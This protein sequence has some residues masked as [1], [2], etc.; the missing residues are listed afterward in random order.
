MH[1]LHRYPKHRRFARFDFPLL[2]ASSTFIL[3]WDCAPDLVASYAYHE[4]A[5]GDLLTDWVTFTWLWVR[6][7]FWCVGLITG[8]KLRFA[9]V[10]YIMYLHFLF[11]SVLIFSSFFC[12]VKLVFTFCNFLCRGPAWFV[13]GESWLFIIDFLWFSWLRRIFNSAFWTSLNKSGDR[14]CPAPGMLRMDES[15]VDTWRGWYFG[16]WRKWF[17]SDICVFCVKW[18]GLQGYILIV[19]P[20]VICASSYLLVCCILSMDTHSSYV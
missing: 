1:W 5:V 18:I 16:W 20:F 19:I 14:T 10:V 9:C 17:S 8:L 7:V 6:L 3:V 4:L 2:Y 12:F 15:L 13:G 11:C